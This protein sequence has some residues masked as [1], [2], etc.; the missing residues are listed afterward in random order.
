MLDYYSVR[1]DISRQQLSKEITARLNLKE[2]FQALRSLMGSIK[3][4]STREQNKRKIQMNK[5]ARQQGEKALDM[6][7]TKRLGLEFL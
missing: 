2:Q 1:T 6:F 4:L 5:L 3:Q 7:L